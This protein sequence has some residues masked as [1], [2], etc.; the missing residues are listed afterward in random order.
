VVRSDERRQPLQGTVVPQGPEDGG[1]GGDLHGLLVVEHREQPRQPLGQHRLAR[2]GRSHE[3]EVM[4]SGSRRLERPARLV[5]TDDVDQVG[6]RRL[7]RSSGRRLGHRIGT[8]PLGQQLIPP[9]ELGE[10]LHGM[11][12]HAADQPCLGR[13]RHR[14]DDVTHSAPGRGEDE[15]QDPAHGPDRS[16]QAQ[17]PDVDDILDHLAGDLARGHQ[18]DHADCEVEVQQRADLAARKR[19]AGPPASMDP[20]TTS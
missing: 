17:L 6:R 14:H 16:V 15:R 7:L 9:D 4:S 11:D 1:D 19:G 10:L 20:I 12:P 8:Q 13:V 2:T 5:L 3:I 18:R